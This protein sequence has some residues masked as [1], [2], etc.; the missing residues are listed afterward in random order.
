MLCRLLNVDCFRA[1]LR[2]DKPQTVF[3]LPASTY[4]LSKPYNGYTGGERRRGAQLLR[5]HVLNGWV[6]PPTTCSVTGARENL[7]FHNETYDRPWTAWVVSR[8]AHYFLHRR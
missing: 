1:I 2:F 5:Y 6:L 7:K 4:P 8:R 3:H